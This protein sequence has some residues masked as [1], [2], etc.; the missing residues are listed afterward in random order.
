MVE[1]LF[2]VSACLTQTAE[3]GPIPAGY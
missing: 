1:P 3:T 2:E